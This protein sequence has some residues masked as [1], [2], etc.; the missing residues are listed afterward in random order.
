MVFSSLNVS[1][2]ELWC[3]LAFIWLA[4]LGSGYFV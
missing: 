1:L 3:D 2:A 4:F